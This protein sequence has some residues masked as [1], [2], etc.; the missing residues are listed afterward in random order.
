MSRELKETRGTKEIRHRST[1]STQR[2]QV[3]GLQIV[4]RGNRKKKIPAVLWDYSLGVADLG[5]TAGIFFLGKCLSNK[6][7]IGHTHAIAD[8]SLLQAALDSKSAIDHQHSP[9]A[10]QNLSLIS[11]WSNYATNSTP[12]CRKLIGDLIEVRGIVKKSSALV[13]NEVIAALP[14]NYRPSQTM[15]IATWGGSIRVTNMDSQG[16]VDPQPPT[17]IWIEGASFLSWRSL[18]RV[19]EGLMQRK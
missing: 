11:G 3:E 4:L 1:I 2:A 8:V 18:T 15:L 5:V 17:T 14:I 12:Q 13:A 6:S 19:G 16:A 9:G 7:P 10:W